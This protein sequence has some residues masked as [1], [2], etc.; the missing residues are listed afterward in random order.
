MPDTG[1]T[2]NVATHFYYYEGGVEERDK[3][4]NIQSTNKEWV[5][6]LKLS[7]PCVAEQR[8]T[9]FTEVA[10]VLFL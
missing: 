9:L 10:A 2:L 3:K 8:S 1:S 7:R 4:R 5:S 6:Y